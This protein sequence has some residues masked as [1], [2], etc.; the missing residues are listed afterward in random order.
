MRDDELEAELER[1]RRA[2]GRLLVHIKSRAGGVLCSASIRVGVPR[3]RYVD[4][5]CERCRGLFRALYHR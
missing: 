2:L 5:T 4:A 3:D 1:D